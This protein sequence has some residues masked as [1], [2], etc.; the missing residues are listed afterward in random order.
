MFLTHCV[1]DYDMLRGHAKFFPIR[2]WSG[3]MGEQKSSPNLSELGAG[4]LSGLGYSDLDSGL[5]DLFYHSLA[6]GYSGEYRLENADGLRIDWPRIPLPGSRSVLESSAA[7]GRRVAG[8]LDSDTRLAGV[9][10]GAVSPAYA[11]LGILRPGPS[12]VDLRV[13]ASWGHLHGQGKVFPG[14]GLLGKVREWTAEESRGWGAAEREALGGAL[15][16][17]LN[18]ELGDG[19]HWSGVPEAAWNFHIGG[20]QAAKKWLSYRQVSVLGRDLRDEEAL[21]FTGMIRRLS[22]LVLLG[23]ELDEN[24]RTA[25]DSAGKSGK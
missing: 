16:V 8:F 5:E 1:G 7:L 22:G 21:H 3:E 11:G 2:L 14:S 19:T 13:E 24:Y 10:S 17:Y 6:I 15:D 23:K 20:Y 4:Y 12:G 25:R 9:D 18:G